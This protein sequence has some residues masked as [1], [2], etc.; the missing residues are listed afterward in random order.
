MLN[1]FPGQD[2]KGFKDPTSV[3]IPVMTTTERNALS[4]DQIRAGF[5]IFNST[6]SALNVWTGSVWRATAA[7]T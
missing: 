3:A 4:A 1:S 6:T 5:V 7:L 2:E